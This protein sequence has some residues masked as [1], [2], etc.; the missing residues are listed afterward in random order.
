MENRSEFLLYDQAV[1]VQE[2]IIVTHMQTPSPYS[3]RAQCGTFSSYD[4]KGPAINP[5]GCNASQDL[6]KSDHAIWKATKQAGTGIFNFVIGDDIATLTD[7]KL[8]WNDALAVA[9]FTPVGK[10]V[11]VGK[12]GLKFVKGSKVDEVAS[13]TSKADDPISSARKADEV[14]AKG[15]V[16]VPSKKSVLK[17]AKLP[18]QGKIRYIPP[19]KW[20][21][22]QPLPKQNG[23]YV[24][25]FGNIWTKGPSRTKG[26]DFEWDVQ[27][28]RQGKN[29]LGDWS[30]DGSHLN[31]SLDGKITHK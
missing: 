2:E 20:T 31:V 1:S 29:Q 4:M 30:R 21:P 12:K 22:S 27:L 14:D 17:D 24:D 11:K 9:S 19:D 18:T 16:N 15:K 28:S 7:G 10:V 8:D 6:E 13:S 26:Q 23:G 25:K 5:K 3:Q